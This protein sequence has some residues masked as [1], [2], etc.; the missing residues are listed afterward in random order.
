MELA[1]EENKNKPRNEAVEEI[2]SMDPL[3]PQ[4]HPKHPPTM[5]KVKS[6]SQVQRSSK[7]S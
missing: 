4:Q 3:P 7:G 5:P 2:C 6:F 1:E